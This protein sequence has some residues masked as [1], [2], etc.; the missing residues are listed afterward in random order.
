[1]RAPGPGFGRAAAVTLLVLGADQLSK[2]VVRA[3][4]VPGE[5]VD[6]PGGVQIVRVAN[7]GIAF[8]LLEGAGSWVL[9]IAALAFAAL[10]MY[11]LASAERPGL[12]LPIGLLAGGAVGNLIDR[13]REGFVTDFIDPPAWPAFNVADIAITLGVVLLV[14]IYVLGIGPGSR[15]TTP[16]PESRSAG[17]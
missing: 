3:E 13:A 11:F 4:V 1:V 5:V 17:P 15:E 9:V 12:W 8:G 10:L 14:S 16:E 2:A 6:L 7:R